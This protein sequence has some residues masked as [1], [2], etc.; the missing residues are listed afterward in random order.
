MTIDSKLQ[1]LLDKVYEEGVARGREAASALVRR[2]ERDAEAIRAE[3]EREAA[4]IRERARA[5]AE[6]LRRNVAS[7]VRLSSEQAL[8]ALK[9]QIRDHLV[10]GA[11]SAPVRDA[12]SDDVFVRELIL[13][14][15]RSWNPGEVDVELAVLLPPNQE[16]SLRSY[17]STRSR[18][19]L[20]EGFRIGV[21]RE[22]D[23]GFRIGPAEGGWL[24]SFTA[25][26]FEA[27][28]GD[29]L[30]PHTKALLF[31]DRP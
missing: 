19:I 26:D 1:A 15:A 3:A 23:R 21:D 12:F 2:A 14:L 5:D 11:I 29:F 24:V 31:G 25:E 17:L 13:T 20:E 18:E 10:S 8:D 30:R 4:E 28:L 7:E 22:L 6:E 9:Q 27:F 16:E